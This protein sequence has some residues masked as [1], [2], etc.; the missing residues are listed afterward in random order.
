MQQ[1]LNSD[2]SRTNIAMNLR[3]RKTIDF[4]KETVAIEEVTVEA[5][6]EEAPAEEAPAE[7]PAPQST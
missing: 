1:H 3:M 2:S 5:K 6:P 7:A 4:L